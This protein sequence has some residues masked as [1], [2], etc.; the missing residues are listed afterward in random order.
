[1]YDQQELIDLVRSRALKFGEFTLAS[2]RKLHTTLMANRLR[3]IPPARD[4]LVK[5]CSI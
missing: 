2:G 1:M 4:S 5:A 3:S